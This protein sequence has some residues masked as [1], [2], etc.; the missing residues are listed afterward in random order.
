[1]CT[2]VFGAGGNSFRIVHLST[3]DRIGVELFQ[4]ENQT[5]PDNN[6]EYWKTDVFHFCVQD[7]N[8]EELAEKIMEDH[9]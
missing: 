4:F 5:N 1:M 9:S 6:F 8:L 3:G 7:P 2:Y